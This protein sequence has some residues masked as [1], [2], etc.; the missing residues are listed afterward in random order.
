MP[1]QEMNV[2]PLPLL[3]NQFFM[4]KEAALSFF[5]T[6]DFVPLFELNP[7]KQ[8]RCDCAQAHTYRHRMCARNVF[9]FAIKRK[10]NHRNSDPSL[11]RSPNLYL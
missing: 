4:A 11:D 10:E 7:Q 2:V 5:Q 3:S 9:S 1:A 8:T 6:T